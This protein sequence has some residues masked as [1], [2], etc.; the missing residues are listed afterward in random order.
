MV[1]SCGAG[2][3]ALSALDIF[4]V[5]LPVFL[6]L[7]LAFLSFLF[8]TGKSV[9]SHS[10]DP[11][12]SLPVVSTCPQLFIL[13]GPVPVKVGW[14]SE[15]MGSTQIGRQE[16]QDPSLGCMNLDQFTNFSSAL[17]KCLIYS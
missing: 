13:H 17:I 9:N 14:T 8:S 16:P 10:C 6:L 2:V 3:M 1:S 11:C 7:F 15:T 12:K 4:S 5:P